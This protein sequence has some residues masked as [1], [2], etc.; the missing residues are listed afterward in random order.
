MNRGILTKWFP[1]RWHPAED[2][3][4]GL[5]DGQLSAK[6]SSKLHAHLKDCWTCRATTERLQRS[7]SSFVEFVDHEFTPSLGTP[8][9]N[10]KKFQS[11]LNSVVTEIGQSSWWSG[12]RDRLVTI[13]SA[14]SFQLR[15]A[16]T[17]MG[18]LIM[19]FLALWSPQIPPVSAQELLQNSIASQTR[20]L[21]G[22]VQPVVYQKLQIRRRAA[23]IMPEQSVVLE[24][25]NDRS[26]ARSYLSV[27]DHTGKQ[28]ISDPSLANETSGSHSQN[29]TAPPLL[30]ELKSIYRENQMEWRQPLSAQNYDAWRNSLGAG[31][32]RVKKTSQHGTEV[33]I[34]QTVPAGA[35]RA[36][37]IVEAELMVRAED[38]HPL[39]Q[40]IEVKGTNETRHYEIIESAYDVIA[41]S[42]LPSSIFKNAIQ[43]RL[44]EP[45]VPPAARLAAPS[46]STA[47]LLEAEIEAQYALH[48][49]KVCLGEPVEVV[50]NPRGQIQVRGLAATEAR[51][52][53]ILAA[54]QV[55]ELVTVSIQTIAEAQAA[56]APATGPA[57]TKED[58]SQ[59]SEASSVEFKNGKLPIQD[60][61][62]RYFT[63]H[64]E[65]ALLGLEER[66]QLSVPQK[67]VTLTREAVSQSEAA[68]QEAWALRRLAE[69]YSPG[70]RAELPPSS[71]W[72]LED[73]VLDHVESLKRAA[74]EARTL[75]T[76]ILLFILEAEASPALSDDKLSEPSAVNLGEAESSWNRLALGVFDPL[77]RT[78]VLIHGLFAGAA[79]DSDPEEAA[80]SLLSQLADVENEFQRL[81][82]QVAR[83]FSRSA[84]RLSLKQP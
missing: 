23:G 36:G 11:R 70:K 49:L 6:K 65:L 74:G 57:I 19:V 34:L 24:L 29:K 42:A 63:A 38:W 32:D 21:R 13:L 31:Q 53:E 44:P 2:E 76:P 1:A 78:R 73:M 80:R 50:R 28:F 5:V 37:A 59:S 84:E 71:Q 64:P 20:R 40:S 43:P 81:Q 14:R 35:I 12:M 55:V 25:W 46:P 58:L 9:G 66:V 68:L 4:I 39:K 72:L 27:E 82:A 52:K 69:W 3:L 26:H 8:P 51:K 79:L 83:E 45:L 30:S 41:L 48:R 16:I 7:I 77:E 75:L 47:E 60:R 61:L 67:I 56:T 33:L 18:L 22:V 10:W 17:S 62:E 54:L 15:W